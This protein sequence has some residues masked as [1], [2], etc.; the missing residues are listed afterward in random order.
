MRLVLVLVFRNGANTTQGERVMTA[1]APASDNTGIVPPWLRDG[2]L[3]SDPNTPIIF[4]AEGSER[5][6]TVDSY[7]DSNVTIPDVSLLDVLSDWA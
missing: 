5:P 7:E 2:H 6:V 3:P 1:I 4:E